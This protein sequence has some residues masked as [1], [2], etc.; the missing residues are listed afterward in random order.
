MPP[1]VPA[2]TPRTQETARA[3]RVSQ[4]QYIEE[5]LMNG[6]P[7]VAVDG[8]AAVLTQLETMQT[9]PD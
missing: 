3:Q 2:G 1:S 5:R 7:P 9:I 6:I 8:V 4:A